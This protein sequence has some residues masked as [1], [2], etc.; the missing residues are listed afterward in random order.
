MVLP[1]LAV[2]WIIGGLSA[3]AGALGIKKG[4]DAKNN[5]Q[6]ARDIIEAAQA[7]FDATKT[8][9]EKARTKTSKSLEKLGKRRL[10]VETDQMTRFIAVVKNIHQASYA[11]ITLDSTSTLVKLPELKEMEASSYQAADILKDGVAAVSSGVLVGVGASGLASSVGVV[12]G[13]G[14]AI[15]SLSGVAATN[16]TLAWLGGGSLASGG[17]GMAGGSAILGG[18]IAGPVL[19]V[20]GYAAA[21]RSEKALTEAYEQESEIRL[22]I[23]QM[24]NGNALLVSIHERSEEMQ[25]IVGKLATRFSGLLNTCEQLVQEKHEARQRMLQEWNAVGFFRKIIRRLKGQKMMDPLDFTNFSQDEKDAYT[26]L[27]LFGMALY[28]MIKVKLLDDDGLITSES[29]RTITE[30]RAMLEEKKR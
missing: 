22:G 16:A 21:S 9:L 12:A 15:G 20:M 4:F 29:D 8:R 6:L 3:A 14:T 27:N 23:E 2:P 19:A 24:E 17:M 30:A 5:Y 7:D 10:Q 11:P 26:V 18:A 1:V 13:T 28:R 25:R